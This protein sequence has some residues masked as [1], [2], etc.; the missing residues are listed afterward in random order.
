M[1]E[2][3]FCYWLQGFFELS[4]STELTPTQ[5]Q[6]I[7]D[8]L[9]LVFRKE[10]PSYP[11]PFFPAPETP[12]PPLPPVFCSTTT[13]FP[14]ETAND[15]SPIACGSSLGTPPDTSLDPE[16]LQS[17]MKALEKTDV[18]ADFAR[19][20]ESGIPLKYVEGEPPRAC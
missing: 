12:W 11:A 10:T 1:R 3:E 15:P 8:H 20:T 4:G 13:D 19:F 5:V 2:L 6:I 17:L 14:F 16:F 7:R 18:K 9:A